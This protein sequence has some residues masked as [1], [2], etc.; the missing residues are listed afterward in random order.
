MPQAYLVGSVK[1]VATPQESLQVIQSGSFDCNHEAVIE[2]TD[3][4]ALSSKEPG[5]Q[6]VRL[7]R[8]SAER[9]IIHSACEQA[10]LLV[11]TDTFFPGWSARVDDNPV[12]I[13]RTNYLF[14]G[15]FLPAGAHKIV[16]S[17]RPLSVFAGIALAAL[18]LL[19]LGGIGIFRI[20]ASCRSAAIVK[21]RSSS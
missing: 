8:P 17:Y 3:S 19:C 18:C 13:Y 6:S 21:D 4:L 16:F 5:R 2:S 11:L 9:V 20:M 15:V 7:Y 12:Q 14:R 1:A 10:T